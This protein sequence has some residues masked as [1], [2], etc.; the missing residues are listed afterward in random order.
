MFGK[1]MAKMD[2]SLGKKQE[3]FSWKKKKIRE[4]VH[5]MVS[6]SEARDSIL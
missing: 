6:S 3:N 4:F 1:D 2:K 5:K